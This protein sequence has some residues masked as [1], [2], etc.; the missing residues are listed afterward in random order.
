MQ[1]KSLHDER[2]S[3]LEKAYFVKIACLLEERTFLLQFKGFLGRLRLNVLFA[4]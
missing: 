1:A 3:I 4:F 2:R